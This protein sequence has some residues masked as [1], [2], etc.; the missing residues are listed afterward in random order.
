MKNGLRIGE[1]AALVGV[2]PDTLRHYERKR[3][4]PAPL[5]TG[6]GYRVYP[7]ESVAR[8]AF[9][10]NALRF[11]FTLKQIAAFI[12][13]RDSG[14]PPCGEVRAAAARMLAEMD[15]QIDEL[16]AARIAV[17]RTLAGWDR[18]LSDA[19]AG[20]PARLLDTLTPGSPSATPLSHR[21]L[22]RRRI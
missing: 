20:A 19:P 11:G 6:A 22:N 9:V 12:G 4:L 15:R 1:V 18:R 10:R 14:R 21:R 16:Q 3:V 17:R 7:P 13:S 2:S 8:I 5:R